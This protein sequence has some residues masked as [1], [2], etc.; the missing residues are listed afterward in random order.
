MKLPTYD[1][2][3]QDTSSGTENRVFALVALLTLPWNAVTQNGSGFFLKAKQ[4]VD[5][6]DNPAP[7]KAS[8]RLVRKYDPDLLWKA[9]QKTV[10]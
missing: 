9:A 3:N 1:V 4:K 8:E 5:V 6:G 2:T 7:V 10:C